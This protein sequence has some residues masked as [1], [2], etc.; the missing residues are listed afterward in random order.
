MQ[1]LMMQQC[2]LLLF[3][4]L[5]QRALS[6]TCRIAVSISPSVFTSCVSMIIT[7]Q[8]MV[9]IEKQWRYFEHQDRQLAQH[10]TEQ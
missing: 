4:H 8:S 3:T 9:K 7:H 5:L 2:E 6:I 1:D 10:F